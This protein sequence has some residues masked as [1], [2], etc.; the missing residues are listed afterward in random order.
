MCMCKC[1]SMSICEWVHVC[2]CVGLWLRWD[3]RTRR[4]LQ[5]LSTCYA[6]AWITAHLH[7]LVTSSHPTG[8]ETQAEGLP[9]TGGVSGRQA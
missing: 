8:E 3:W 6:L 5:C 9:V 1:Q 4:A 2:M 7:Y